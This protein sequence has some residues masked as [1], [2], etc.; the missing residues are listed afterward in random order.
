[1]GLL[2]R[3]EDWWLFLRWPQQQNTRGC[4]VKILPIPMPSNSA[5]GL[6]FVPL[7]PSATLADKID[8]NAARAT[9]TKDGIKRVEAHERTEKQRD[10]V[11]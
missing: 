2:N 3:F 11:Y 7:I 8:S 6:C 10:Q 9:T 5:F 1:M 4:P